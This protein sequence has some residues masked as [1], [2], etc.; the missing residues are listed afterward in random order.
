MIQWGPYAAAEG[1]HGTDQPARVIAEHWGRRGHY[2][3]YARAFRQGLREW[4]PAPVLGG[5]A[6]SGARYLI[7]AAKHHDGFA[8]WPARARNPRKRGWQVSRDVVGE[9]AD[10]ARAHGL[11]YGLFYS[12]GLDWT[13]GGTPLR[14]QEDPSAA[15]PRTRN[16]AAFVDAQLR[17]LISRY[18]PSLLWNDVGSP[19]GHDL[20]ALFSD[21]YDAVPDGVVNDR[22]GQLDGQDRGEG[23]LLA[24]AVR[25]LFAPRASRIP[26]RSRTALSVRH[27]DYRTVESDSSIVDH[28]GAWEFIR[29]EEGGESLLPVPALIHELCTVTAHGGNLLLRVRPQ[30]DGSLDA[31]TAARLRGL[32]EWLKLNG[33]AIYG[34]RPWGE[35]EGVTEDG[36]E[37]RFTTKGMTAYAILQGTPEGRSIVLP[38]LR[39]LPY[40]GL[41]VLGS[42]SYSTWFQEGRDVHIRLTEP[43]RDSPAHVISITPQPR[44]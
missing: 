2:D 23:F 11:R 42:I 10:G 35:R 43:L 27:A 22:F 16:Y 36:V 34:T 25:R 12:S 1:G 38:G 20:R 28:E 44:A 24:R 5:I 39:L 40:A 15:I 29:P 32:G 4:D 30:A 41:R 7:A 18:S 3:A 19:A 37:V 26:A 17:E 31:V 21:Y 13:F 8:L 33:E 6:A 9:L 14:D